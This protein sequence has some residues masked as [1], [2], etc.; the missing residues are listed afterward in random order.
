MTRYLL[1]EAK[2]FTP[3]GLLL[4]P[5]FVGILR[6]TGVFSPEEPETWIGW[7]SF[8]EYSYPVLFPLLFFNLL[9]REKQW[10]SLEVMVAT[11]RKKGVIF[12]I[13]SL[14]FLLLLALVAFVAV[15]P[16]EYLWVLAPGLAL[17][18][19]ALFSGLF[20]G[21]EIGLGISLC[22]WGFSFALA[23]AG[24]GLPNTG[25]TSW[26]VLFLTRLGLTP[27]E[28]LQRKW[29]HLGAGLVF[30]TLAFALTDYKRS[31]RVR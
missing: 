15:R 14:L 21:E 23:V 30:L 18:G 11:P 25:P 28:L 12:L 10:R 19:V 4:L 24:S 31:W 13:R 16:Q 7:L 2:L 29:A 20:L 17:G 22:W 26:F 6:V 27:A 8:L 1:Y 5:L 3:W 9:N